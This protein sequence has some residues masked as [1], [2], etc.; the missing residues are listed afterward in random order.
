MGNVNIYTNS[1]NYLNNQP[2][3]F[4]FNEKK[5]TYLKN[6]QFNSRSIDFY[7]S[8][9]F[10][11]Y[12]TTD[13]HLIELSD[14]PNSFGYIIAFKSQNISGIPLRV[15]LKNNS[16]FLCSIEDELNK[17]KELSWDYFLIPSTGDS[18]GYKID[19]NNI[20]YGNQTSKSILEKV[21]VIPIPFQLL[22]QIKTD[23][24]KT[25]TSKYL[26]FNQSF[27]KNWL[28]FYF[29]GPKPVFLK[30]HTLANNWANAWEI[31]QNIKSSQ[32]HIIFWP[33]LLQF[34]AFA[35]TISTII[36]LFERSTK[37]KKVNKKV[38]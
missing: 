24:Q 33:Q 2:I 11:S 13:S 25:Q 12:N 19:I 1:Q 8:K 14:V 34:I 37:R 30:N 32:V 26:I 20:S 18:I 23:Y 15:C 6:I 35:I 7:P 28:A 3:N 29:N 38:K 16:S 27:N 21:T 10:D 5:V 17:N 31:P 4:N 36:Y 9:T 22:S